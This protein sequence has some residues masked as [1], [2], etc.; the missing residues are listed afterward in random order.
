M[1]APSHELTQTGYLI[2]GPT[3][4]IQIDGFDA[5]EV[6]CR[7]LGLS[8]MRWARALL[9]AEIEADEAF[10]ADNSLEPPNKLAIDFSAQLATAAML[11]DWLNQDAEPPDLHAW[12]E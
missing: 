2:I 9:D 3:G 5:D 4:R 11:E 1:S 8:A 7:E 6:T 10:I 12:M